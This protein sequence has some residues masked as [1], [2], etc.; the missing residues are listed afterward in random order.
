MNRVVSAVALVVVLG[1]GGNGI[2]AV[3]EPSNSLISLPTE[4]TLQYG[5]ERRV[6]GVLRLS[7]TQVLEDSR[8][9]VDVICVWAGNAKIR[10]GISMG[11]GPTFPLELNSMLEPRTV[12]WNGVRVTLLE[13][14]PEPRSTETIPPEAY[15]VRLR[16]EAVP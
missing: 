5:E 1:C 14:T 15:A 10:I 12:D 13:V 4:I 9:A 8:C 11:M 3:D 2:D 6:D 7:F 16:L